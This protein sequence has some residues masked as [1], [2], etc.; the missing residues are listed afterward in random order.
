MPDGSNRLEV[1]RV[2]IEAP[3]TS[4]RYPHFLIGRQLTYDLPPPSTIYGHVASALGELPDR[5]SFRFGYHFQAAAKA[6][7]LEHQH[8]VT[9]AG[10]KSG[11]DLD[12]HKHKTNIDANIQPHLREFVFRPVLTLYL[13]PPELGH[14]L[15]EPAF[16]VILGRSQDLACIVEV[17][18]IALASAS[19]A[20]LERTLLP[21]SFRT[22]IG[23][24]TTV[25]M[26]RFIEPP[27][28]RAAHFDRFISLAHDRI[29]AGIPD[30]PDRVAT[31][32]RLFGTTQTETWWVDPDTPEWLGAKRG[33]VFHSFA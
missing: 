18:E 17:K 22:R 20:Y 21:F 25:N 4:F 9:A 26:P 2:R 24:G 30:N 19:R 12:G 29:F 15:R 16:C 33:I 3:A 10:P 1:V 32:Q 28:E 11:F 13:D 5:N 8:V 27:P 23:L 7:D 6:A 14:A 31:T